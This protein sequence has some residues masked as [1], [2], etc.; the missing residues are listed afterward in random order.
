MECRMPK[1]GPALG[2]QV[3]SYTFSEGLYAVDGPFVCTCNGQNPEYI[4]ETRKTR[5][6][7]GVFANVLCWYYW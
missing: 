1:L 4:T 3:T 5:I 7:P 2:V 6:G